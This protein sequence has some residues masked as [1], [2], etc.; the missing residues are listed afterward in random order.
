MLLVQT[1]VPMHRSCTA[2]RMLQPFMIGA[3]A[4]AQG[5]LDPQAHAHRAECHG[6]GVFSGDC[7]AAVA[8]NDACM[9]P[10]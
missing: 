5:M 1:S 3:L 4:D 2:R 7:D 10:Q 6:V 8:I 9:W